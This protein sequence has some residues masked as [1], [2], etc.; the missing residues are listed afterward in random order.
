MNDVIIIGA[1]ASGLAAAYELSLVNKKIIVLE[2]RDRLGGRIHSIKDKRFKGIIEAGAEFIHGKLPVTLELL[3]KAG[4][5]YHSAEGKMLEIENGQLKKSDVF[6]DWN[7][8]MK[9]LQ[10]LEED[11]SIKEFLEQ[12]FPDKKDKHLKES[13]L[14]FVEGY[15]AADT[16]KA[17]SF[18]LREEWEKE[19]DNH[20]ER[21]DRGYAELI[22]FL[23]DETIKRGNEILLSHI[24]TS[25]NWEKGDVTV[26]TDNQQRFTASKVL[27][28]L[29]LGVWQAEGEE[30]H[31]SFIPELLEK[32]IAAKKMG[33]G[34][35]IKINFQFQNQ[36]W[37]QETGNKIQDAGFIFSDYNIP[38]WWTQHPIKNGMLTGWMAGPKALELKNAGNEEILNEALKTLA[39]I[40][41]VDE[42]FIK[43]KMVGH[44]ITNWTADPFTR[45]AYSYAT[46]DTHWAKKLLSE[47]ME[48]TLYFGG[49]ALYEGRETG[50]VEGALANGIQVA[51][52]MISDH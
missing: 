22:S 47:P 30:G 51:Q 20:Q 15:D 18:A 23:A 24:V 12:N 25:V 48:Q 45:G 32:K 43:E 8:L 42:S 37:E 28:T 31:V 44:Y 3:K 5:K 1:G 6:M 49:E 34:A 21:I 40:F 29:P 36:F 10:A 7:K 13:V 4:I 46:L 19:D 14:K 33:Y 17:S 9:Q 16:A 26:I 50:T 38:T 52:K 39:Y 11:I 2:A 41:K 27:I 35:V